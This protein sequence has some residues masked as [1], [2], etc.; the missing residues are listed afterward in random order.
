MNRATCQKNLYKFH[1]F[2]YLQ[3]T[4]QWLLQSLYRRF[5]AVCN[6]VDAE[7]CVFS[8]VSHFNTFTKWFSFSR[9]RSLVRLLLVEFFLKWKST[10]KR[11]VSRKPPKA[12][13]SFGLIK[14]ASSLIFRPYIIIHCICS[15]SIVVDC[16]LLIREIVLVLWV[17]S[18]RGPRR[19][20]LWCLAFETETRTHNSEFNIV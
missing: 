14:R 9:V 18:P 19:H 10:R 15:N 12:L 3:K 8:N 5:R 2:E 7:K 1:T 6:V 20:F 11:K 13:R 16:S 17:S 4:F